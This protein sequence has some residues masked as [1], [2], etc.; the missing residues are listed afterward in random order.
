VLVEKREWQTDSDSQLVAVQAEGGMQQRLLDVPS[1]IF[2][3]ATRSAEG[4]VKRYRVPRYN[5]S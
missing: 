3:P 5:E 2:Q 1:Q 4:P